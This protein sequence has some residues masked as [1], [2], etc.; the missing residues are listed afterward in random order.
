MG[1]A[2]EYPRTASLLEDSRVGTLQR[3]HLESYPCFIN[4]EHLERKKSAP[5]R[6]LQV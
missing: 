5:I 3:G 4:V 1:D 6:G 2:K